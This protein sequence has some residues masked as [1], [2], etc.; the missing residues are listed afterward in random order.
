MSYADDVALTER[1]NRQLQEIIKDES[2]QLTRWESEK[3][4][5]MRIKPPEDNKQLLLTTPHGEIKLEVVHEFVSWSCN[6]KQYDEEKEIVARLIRGNKFA[7][8]INHLVRSKRS[9]IK[10]K[11]EI[12][13]GFIRAHNIVRLRDLDGKEEK[14]RRKKV[15]TC[16]QEELTRKYTIFTKN[17]K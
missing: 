16:R 5:F 11:I 3:S 2:K 12:L 17:K 6:N 4:K 9:S 1:T 8:A 10:Q 13:Q 14:I 15:E 7:V